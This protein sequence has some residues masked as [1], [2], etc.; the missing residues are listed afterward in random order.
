[1]HW[2]PASLSA[3]LACRAACLTVWLRLALARS[4]LLPSIRSFSLQLSHSVFVISLKSL[5]R[6][7]R[8][9]LSRFRAP[10]HPSGYRGHRP[11]PSSY[12]SPLW[13]ARFRPLSLSPSRRTLSSFAFSISL[14]HA[15]LHDLSRLYLS[16]RPRHCSIGRPRGVLSRSRYPYPISRHVSSRFLAAAISH[17]CA[18][19]FR[20]SRVRN[21]HRFAYVRYR[22]RTSLHLPPLAN[23]APPTTSKSAP[24]TCTPISRLSLD[25]ARTPRTLCPSLYISLFLSLFL[26]LFSSFPRFTNLAYLLIIVCFFPLTFVALDRHELL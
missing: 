19:L 13:P 11:S 16:P 23:G 12:R 20:P 25:P 3:F 26:S 18:S 24:P 8:Y 4:L 22:R 6:S 5:S 21:S 1:M 7:H 9:D 10:F 14:S 15:S 2:L 17:A